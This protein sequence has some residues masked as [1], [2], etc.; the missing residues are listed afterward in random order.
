[1]VDCL[2]NCKNTESISSPNSAFTDKDDIEIEKYKAH[3]I[4]DITAVLRE[5]TCTVLKEVPGSLSKIENSS[6][7]KTQIVPRQL[8]APEGNI[9][10]KITSSEKILEHSN[11]RISAYLGANPKIE[12]T[13]I[14]NNLNLNVA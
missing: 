8:H 12:P 14:F 4:S 1:M 11:I 3:R 13:I 10:S 2:S 7:E 9:E 6:Y 5:G